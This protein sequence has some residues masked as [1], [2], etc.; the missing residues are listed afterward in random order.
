MS[1]T[2]TNTFTPCPPLE[3]RPVA[4]LL[5]CQAPRPLLQNSKSQ[6]VPT[7]QEKRCRGCVNSLQQ[8]YIATHHTTCMHLASYPSTFYFSPQVD[9]SGPLATLRKILLSEESIESL[10]NFLVTHWYS[11]ILM[12]VAVLVLMVRIR[13]GEV[14][15]IRV[16]RYTSNLNLCQCLGH[17]HQILRQEDAAGAEEAPQ[18]A[19]LRPPRPGDGR[20]RIADQHRQQ[21]RRGRHR[22]A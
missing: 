21:S 6:S 8:L 19:A 10:R 14:L 9:P 22:Y 7:C 13:E 16:A 11:V 4:P 2:N 12:A 20:R 18:P 3:I 17:H 15:I 1:R 5:T